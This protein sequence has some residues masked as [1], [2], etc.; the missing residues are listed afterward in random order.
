MAE[1]TDSLL[2]SDSEEFKDKVLSWTDRWK[3]ARDGAHPFFILDPLNTR[4]VRQLKLFRT[5]V[6]SLCPVDVIIDS[7]G[8]DMTDVALHAP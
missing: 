1:Y 8:G 4:V 7:F 3:E 2:F 5:I 6:P